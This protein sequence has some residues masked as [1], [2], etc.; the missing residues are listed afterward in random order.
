MAIWDWGGG[1]EGKVT[2]VQWWLP[3]LVPGEDWALLQPP[4]QPL[5]SLL[6]KK[7]GKGRDC[8]NIWAL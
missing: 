4:L 6:T 5:Q 8:Q 3:T 1:E 2:E 7:S